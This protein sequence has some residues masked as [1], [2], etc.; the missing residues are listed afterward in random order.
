M[1]FFSFLITVNYLFINNNNNNNNNN[2]SEL[3]RMLRES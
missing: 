3:F 2:N 1:Y